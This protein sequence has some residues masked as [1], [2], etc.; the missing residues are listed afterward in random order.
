MGF[1]ESRGMGCLHVYSIACEV[2]IMKIGIWIAI[3]ISAIV[4]FIVG[5]WYDQPLHW[6]L[7]ILMIIIGFFIHAIILILKEK[8]ENS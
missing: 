6:Y 5:N 3:I 2:R 4:S 1:L 8:D 7:F